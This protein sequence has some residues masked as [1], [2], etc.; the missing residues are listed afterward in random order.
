[1]STDATLIKGNAEL[2]DSLRQSVVLL[3]FEKPISR[4]VVHHFMRVRLNDAMYAD[5]EDSH[6]QADIV[7]PYRVGE[8]PCKHC[9][10]R[11]RQVGE[12]VQTCPNESCNHHLV[13]VECGPLKGVLKLLIADEFVEPDG[14]LNRVGLMLDRRYNTRTLAGVYRA[15]GMLCDELGWRLV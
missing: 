4:F 2:P 1:M 10:T 14:S 15:A 12:T 9:G 8:K 7:Q 3:R 11:R 6:Y 5:G 13:L